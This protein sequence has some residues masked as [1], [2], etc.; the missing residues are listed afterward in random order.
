MRAPEPPSSDVP[1][2]VRGEELRGHASTVDQ[3]AARAQRASEAVRFV[4]LDRD[5]Y[6]QICA[7]VPTL[8]G[9]VQA[10]LQDVAEAASAALRGSAAALRVAAAAYEASDANAVERLNAAAPGPVG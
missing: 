9:S 1:V 10:N 7:F 5:A 4:R 2:E 6:G 3:L 8:L